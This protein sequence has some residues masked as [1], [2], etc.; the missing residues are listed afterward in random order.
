MGQLSKPDSQLQCN[1]C[2]FYDIYQAGILTVGKYIFR[3]LWQ[4]L[5]KVQVEI[6]LEVEVEVEGLLG[7]SQ[8]DWGVSHITSLVAR[9][10]Q[11]VSQ[12]K[13]LLVI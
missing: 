4:G 11:H 12:K 13:Y 7:V 2:R 8:G 10:Y 9:D 3:E 1:C 5:D 6:I